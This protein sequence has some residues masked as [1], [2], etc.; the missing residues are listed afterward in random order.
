MEWDGVVAAIDGSVDRKTET[1]GAGFVVGVGP[2]PD[3]SCFFPVGG[4]LASLRAEAA[5][6]DG[7]L[8]RVEPDRP[9]L[10][11][12]DCLILL[13]LLLR[14]GRVDFWP[15]P[16]DVKH[17]DVIGSCLQKLR[18]RTGRTRLV[19]VKS[20]SGLLMND[21]ADALAEQG[22]VCEEPPRW[23]A[24]RKPHQLCLSVRPSVRKIHPSLPDDN[25]SDTLLIRR[26]VE[27][28]EL[29]A[30]RMKGTAFSRLMLQ[31][32]AN[33]GP[34]L[35]TIGSMPD[36]T[37][38][39]WMQTVSGQYPTTA[40]LHKMFPQKYRTAT[41]PWCQLGVPETLG[42]FLSMCPKFREARTE[43]HNRCWRD[44][45]RVLER[46]SPASWKFFLDKPMSDTG[47]LGAQNRL[48]EGSAAIT[49]MAS[50]SGGNAGPNLLRLRPDAVAVNHELKKIAIL[51]HC[52]PY[53]NV[54]EDG[55]S[56]PSRPPIFPLEGEDVSG[57]E[58]DVEEVENR[59][60][61]GGS[62][63]SGRGSDATL[64]TGEPFV[65]VK[66]LVSGPNRRSMC[67][68]YAR[69]KRKYQDLAN[70]LSALFRS[71]GWKVQVLPWVV[72][73]RGVLDADG[74][75]KAMVFMEVPEQRRKDLLRR[76]AVASVE[77]LVFM[78]R[79]RKSGN[80]R[81]SVPVVA[82]GNRVRLG[83][84]RRAGEDAYQCMERWKRLA[85]DPMRLN[86]Q[87]RRG[88]G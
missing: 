64:E 82:N 59:S 28:V 83:E 30:A 10:V 43:A 22:R 15:D 79:V 53:D 31:D 38:R 14:W 32:P 17:F 12:T 26:A 56:R 62:D 25:V 88:V 85:T 84:K 71:Q 5:G 68:A 13:M 87:S 72:G 65:D 4:P 49:A 61:D 7:L 57:E 58:P 41:C 27:R 40:R 2:Q 54:E 50:Q 80:L 8:D 29:S 47:L 9:L 77:A 11:F 20:H 48:G 81:V 34:V 74:I 39:L 33:C 73:T 44:I 69:K 45:L 35:E 63:N 86:L 52:R 19:K 6:L 78:H 67:E 23:P 66:G 18:K 3:D 42:H 51:E 60:D 21:R 24:P 76:T 37:V 16:E 55:P 36:S 70:S 1:M 46:V 75:S